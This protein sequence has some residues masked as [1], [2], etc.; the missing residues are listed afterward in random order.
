[1]RAFF[2]AFYSD[3][4][5]FLA[6]LFLAFV[7]V[8]PIVATDILPF[9]DLPH[10]AALSRLWWDVLWGK[11]EATKHYVIDW[12][13]MP[14]WSI[15]V[16]FA[17]LIRIFGALHAARILTAFCALCVPLAVLRFRHALG[18]SMAPGLLAFVIV[19]DFNLSFGWLNHVLGVALALFALA[20]LVKADSPRRALS[21]WPWAVLLAFTHVL[22]FGFF[23]LAA[24]LLTLVRPGPKKKAF[25]TLLV[26]LSLPSLALV[27][28]LVRTLSQAAVG[29][30]SGAVYSSFATRVTHLFEYTLGGAQASDRGMLAAGLLF[31]FLIVLPLAALLLPRE[32]A[33]PLDRVSRAPFAAATLLYFTLPLSVARPVEHWGTYP[34]F[35]SLMLLGVLIAVK[36]AISARRIFVYTI[37]AALLGLWLSVEITISFRRF[38]RDAAAFHEIAAHVPEGASLLP[39]A[40]HTAFEGTRHRMGE[41]IHAYITADTGGYNPYLFGQP[42]NPVHYIKHAKLPAPEGWGRRPETFSMLIHGQRY[43]YLLV[44]GRADDPVP[45]WIGLALEI[46]ADRYRL[47]KILEPR[48]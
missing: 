33:T 42:T 31:T 28:W 47:Y 3:K 1:M 41:S 37:P 25:A 34:R 38:S 29:K 24:A 16:L 32:K 36:P 9:I 6:A 23:G 14:Y 39:L 44:I 46:E 4:P 43:A 11:P 7:G 48:R 20:A 27:P 30:P 10:H 19:V 45:E 12:M 18:R 22:P 21:V 17:P 13:P 26:A 5:L 2:K 8:F 35:A 40:Y 15:Y